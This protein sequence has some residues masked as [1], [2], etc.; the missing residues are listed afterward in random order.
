MKFEAEQRRQEREFQLR[1][2]QIFNAS[3]RGHS[4]GYSCSYSPYSSPPP[5][6]FYYGSDNS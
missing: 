6:E 2:V 3:Q 4:S 1:M 5:S